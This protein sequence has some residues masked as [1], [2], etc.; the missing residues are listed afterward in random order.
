LSFGFDAGA[1]ETVGVIEAWLTRARR[2]DTTLE[3]ADLHQAGFAA[4]DHALRSVRGTSTGPNATI[5]LVGTRVVTAPAMR[6]ERVRTCVIDKAL[7]DD[8]VA[9]VI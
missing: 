2:D 8:A 4:L 6:V 3:V 1:P 5:K 9:V 7:V